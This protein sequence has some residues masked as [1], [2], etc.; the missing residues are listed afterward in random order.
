MMDILLY[1]RVNGLTEVREFSRVVE[2]SGTHSDPAA[3]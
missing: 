3:P 1:P 2:P